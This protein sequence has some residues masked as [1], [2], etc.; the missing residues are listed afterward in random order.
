[1]QCVFNYFAVNNTCIFYTLCLLIPLYIIHKY[2]KHIYTIK[3]MLLKYLHILTM[4]GTILDI[5][6]IAAEISSSFI[7]QYF[8]DD[9]FSKLLF[10]SLSMMP[11]SQSS[12]CAEAESK[13]LFQLSLY[14]F[15]FSSNDII[16]SN[17]S[18]KMQVNFIQIMYRWT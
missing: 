15:I 6:L 13:K 2:Y 7:H 9:T 10:F 3:F 5:T 4:C 11:I 17:H 8:V 12:L 14:L 18:L 16:L 1:M